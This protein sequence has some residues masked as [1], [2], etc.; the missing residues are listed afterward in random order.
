MVDNWICGTRWA[1]SVRREQ[2]GS[3]RVERGRFLKWGSWSS[4]TTAFGARIL[5]LRWTRSMTV[6]SARERN[7]SIFIGCD[8]TRN[9][10]FGRDSGP[11]S[12][13]LGSSSGRSWTSFFPSP[14]SFLQDESQAAL[15][16]SSSLSL[17]PFHD[18]IDSPFSYPPSFYVAVVAASSWYFSFLEVLARDPAVCTPFSICLGSS[19]LSACV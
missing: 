5:T 10:W 15:G 9:G 14:S 2:G 3:L 7:V 8:W 1:R 18:Q 19:G 16:G 6:F 17:S 13:L 4:W 11:G 12:V